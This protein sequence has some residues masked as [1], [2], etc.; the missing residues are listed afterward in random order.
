MCE[1]GVYSIF[2]FTLN[3]QADKGLYEMAQR[4]ADPAA[5]R[6]F[7]IQ[8]EST[9]AKAGDVGLRNPIY[10]GQ[11]ASIRWHSPYLLGQQIVRHLPLDIYRPSHQT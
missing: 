7:L 5:P 9:C 6:P 8:T 4:Q 10:P 11:H 3:E 2:Y 1:E